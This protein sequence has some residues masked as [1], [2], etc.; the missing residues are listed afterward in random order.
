MRVGRNTPQLIQLEQRS[1]R[2]KFGVAGLSLHREFRRFNDTSFEQGRQT[3]RL[4]LHQHFA[5]SLEAFSGF[6]RRRR[7][8]LRG[9]Q[10]VRQHADSRRERSLEPLVT[11]FGQFD[12]SIRNRLAQSDPPRP[13]KRLD[14]GRRPGDTFCAKTGRAVAS[15]LV[16][17]RA[18]QFGVRQ[19]ARRFP[20]RLDRGD[21]SLVEIQLGILLQRLADERIERERVC[22]RG[23]RL[24]RGHA[25]CHA[26]E[27][28]NQNYAAGKS[29]LHKHRSSQQGMKTSRRVNTPRPSEASREG[30][31]RKRTKER[32]QRQRPGK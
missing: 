17:D 31:L 3:G 18:G 4:A 23:H 28:G 12:V 16:S 14:D 29:S 2:G 27:R 24:I 5:Q 10:S 7:L 26:S 13:F 9:E 22:G 21:F 1:L 8:F 32:A 11:K 15:R 25:R 6:S 30:Q 19:Q 20:A